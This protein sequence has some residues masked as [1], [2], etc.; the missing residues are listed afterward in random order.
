MHITVTV[1]DLC[2]ILLD[3]QQRAPVQRGIHH[4]GAATH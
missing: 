3:H 4:I 2:F 1:M